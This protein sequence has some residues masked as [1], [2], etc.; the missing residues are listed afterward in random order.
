MKRFLL[1]PLSVLLI[2]G[3]LILSGSSIL[4]K[5][6]VE[7]GSF[8]YGNLISWTALIALSLSIYFGINKINHPI[9]FIHK[10]FSYAYRLLIIL[11]VLW[12]FVSYYLAS[13]WA[14]TFKQ[15]KEF[16]GS[17]DAAEYFW[18]YTIVCVLFPLIYILLYWLILLAKHLKRKV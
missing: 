10:T 15:Q 8:P 7:G 11:P 4:T 17:S 16:R 18:L 9:T 2:C 14:F 6:I 3:F 5:P 1:I 12:G 13:N